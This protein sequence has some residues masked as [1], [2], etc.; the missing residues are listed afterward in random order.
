[1]FQSALFTPDC[2]KLGPPT[3]AQ[4]D[5]ASRGFIHSQVAVYAVI[6]VLGIIGCFFEEEMGATASKWLGRLYMLFALTPFIVDSFSPYR[7]ESRSAQDILKVIGP[8]T[9]ESQLYW[10]GV[11]AQKRRFVQA[12]VQ[13]LTKWN[14]A[15]QAT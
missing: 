4:I 14:K 8:P 13:L 7:K 15:R 2:I 6:L 12:E 5:G 10:E 11:V 1:M 9:P 3:E